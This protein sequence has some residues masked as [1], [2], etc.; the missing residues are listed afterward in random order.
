MHPRLNLSQR[1]SHELDQREKAFSAEELENLPEL[2]RLAARLEPK[3]RKQF[4]D[5]VEAVK[6]QI[7]LEHLATA[8]LSN[9]LTAIELAA[10]VEAFRDVQSAFK[11]TMLEGFL[12]G[13][14]YSLDQLEEVALVMNL[15]LVNPEAIRWAES[16]A[17]ELVTNLIQGEK[18]SIQALI[19]DATKGNSDVRD[20]AKQLRDFIGLDKRREKAVLKYQ[21]ELIDGGF[22]VA[23]I[24]KRLEKYTAA[25][26]KDRSLTIARTEIIH[27]HNSG[28]QALW[29]EAIKNGFL[30]PRTMQK[31]WIVTDDDRLDKNICLPLDDEVVDIQEVFHATN[32]FHMTPPAHPRCRCAVGLVERK[33]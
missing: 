24:R 1:I 19:I 32:G 13:A 27:A 17:A 18:E 31:Q 8:I 25:Q 9:N 16:S 5:A 10:Q 2:V 28:Q 14:N 22:D 29:N 20:T 12:R 3:L 23:T 7:N 6:S 26:L 15:N 21:Q 11:S 30:N 33:R 4:L